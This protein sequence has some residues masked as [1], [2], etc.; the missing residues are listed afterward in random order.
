MKCPSCGSASRRVVD[1]RPIEASIRRRSECTSC[2]KRYTTYE[3]HSE[4][5]LEQQATVPY[6]DRDEEDNT[7]P[8]WQWQNYDDDGVMLALPNPSRRT[9]G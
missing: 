3:M 4:E 9:Y 6:F 7:Q 5:L 2:K 8:D 1:S